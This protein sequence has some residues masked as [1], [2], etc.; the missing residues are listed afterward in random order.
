MGEMARKIRDE[1]DVRRDIPT[2]KTRLDI[3]HYLDNIPDSDSKSLV[4][5]DTH[6]KLSAVVMQIMI[7]IGLGTDH[8]LA[9]SSRS[10]C[11]MKNSNFSFISMTEK[12]GIVYLSSIH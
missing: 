6:T 8:T 3:S 11:L 10:E 12:G 9:V 5:A 4:Y 2:A 7:Y 1:T